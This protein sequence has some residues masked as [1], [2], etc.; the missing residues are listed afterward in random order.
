MMNNLNK[1]LLTLCV[2]TAF[3]NISISQTTGSF[4]K[5]LTVDGVSRSVEYAVPNTYNANEK[6]G[7]LVALP[8]CG[9]TSKSAEFRDQL[10]FMNADFKTIVVAPHGI[11]SLYYKMDDADSTI[12]SKSIQDA[13]STYNIDESHVFLTGFS[14][15][16]YVATKYGTYSTIY[17]F[18]GIIPY[19]AGISMDEINAGD[20]NLETDVPTCICIGDQDP[21]LVTNK[22]IADSISHYGGNVFLNEMPGVGHTTGNASFKDEVSE[23]MQWMKNILPPLSVNEEIEHSELVSW[24]NSH[25]KSLS[26]DLATNPKNAKLVV[27]DVTGKLIYSTN[28]TK[29]QNRIDL[30]SFPEGI[31]FAS[32]KL[33]K[34]NKPITQAFVIE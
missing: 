5:N 1:L 30:S 9:N 16:G 17:P 21:N 8:G 7:L 32:I 33:S 23:C 26:F 22:T 10:D 25:G 29:T 2:S 4:N 15:N 28:I 27:Y 11:S 3:S 13:L 19:N 20:F 12:I 14:C 31:V 18:A 24:N 6:Y 34:H